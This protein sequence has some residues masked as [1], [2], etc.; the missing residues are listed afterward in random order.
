MAIYTF[1]KNM[2][3]IHA[4]AFTEPMSQIIGNVSVGIEFYM[5]LKNT[6]P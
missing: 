1:K 6:W 5:V 2:P 4:T 3:D